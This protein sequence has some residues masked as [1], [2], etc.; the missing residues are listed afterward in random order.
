[1]IPCRSFKKII[2]LCKLDVI[3]INLQNAKNSNLCHCIKHFQP[4]AHDFSLLINLLAESQGLPDALRILALF[5]HQ[6]AML[7]EPLN[8]RLMQ[9]R[10]S[11]GNLNHL[12]NDKKALNKMEEVVEVAV[13]NQEKKN[14]LQSLVISWDD[15][16]IADYFYR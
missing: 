10:N 4:G 8:I 16:E 7:W 6:F 13:K 2:L 9:R 5:E 11:L 15:A 14:N 12:D 1:M 3:T